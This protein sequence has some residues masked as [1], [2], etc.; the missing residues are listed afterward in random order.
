MKRSLYQDAIIDHIKSSENDLLVEAKPGSGKTTIVVEAISELDDP[1]S[2]L[3]LAF[4]NTIA[5]SIQTKVHP[6]ATVSNSH[7]FG[8]SCLKS[9]SYYEKSK[10]W[11]FAINNGKRL[12]TSQQVSSLFV[13]VRLL[14]IVRLSDTDIFC[15]KAISIVLSMSYEYGITGIRHSDEKLVQFLRDGV[16]WGQ[17]W[18]RKTGQID[19]VDMLYLPV[20]LDLH[21]VE[22]YDYV[23]VDEVQDFANIQLHLMQFAVSEYGKLIMVGDQ[24]QACFKFAGAGSASIPNLKSMLNPDTLPLPIC[25]RCPSSHIDLANEIYPGMI[26][27]HNAP[28]GEIYNRF[29]GYTQ[30]QIQSLAKPNDL[31]ICRRTAPLIEECLEFILAGKPAVVKGK[32]VRENLF[33]TFDEI[34]K[35]KGFKYTNVMQFVHSWYDQQK[36]YFAEEFHNPDAAIEELYDR[37]NQAVACIQAFNA[38]SIQELKRKIE[39]IFDDKRGAVQLS[40]IHSAKGLEAD[41]VFVLESDYLPF[42]FP[43]MSDTDR[44]QENN[45]EYIAYTRSKNK[46]YLLPKNNED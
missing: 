9:S 12:V 40:S 44:I 14:E 5:K 7:S 27:R 19:F 22:K 8:K 38:Q 32:G 17:E 35:Q 20:Q 41:T 13:L 37:F 46:L 3:T 23:F 39:S 21:P 30:S 11:D 15:D 43:G 42:K 33:R 1:S 36:R 2:V 31:I 10:Y 16:T 4:T 26:P 28:I 6:L 18:Y 25:Y 45:L 29:D 24:D 34:G